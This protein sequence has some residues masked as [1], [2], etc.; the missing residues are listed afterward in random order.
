M[1]LMYT[2]KWS[3][4]VVCLTSS[5]GLE[6]EVVGSKAVGGDIKLLKT[7]WKTAEDKLGTRTRMAG[8]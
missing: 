3:T 5:S 4:T 1:L 8:T 2:A 6:R 7:C